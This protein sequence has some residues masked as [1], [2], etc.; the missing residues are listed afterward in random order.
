MLNLSYLERREKIEA[1]FDRT[2]ADAWKRLTSTEPVSG[3]RKTVREGRDR[4]RAT[5]LS[6][7]PE[8]MAGMRMLDAGC[9]TGALAVEAA[10]RGATVVAIDLSPTLVDLAR[11]RSSGLDVPGSIQY[12]AGDMLHPSHGRFDYI[13]CMDSLIHYQATDTV[14]ALAG[15]ISR[16][17]QAV[18]TTFAPQTPSLAIMRAVGRMFPKGDRA[19]WIE[20]VSFDTLKSLIA[21]EPRC[22]GWNP[23]RTQRISSSFY[24]S[25]ALELRR[26]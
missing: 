15:L 18:I 1:Y 20:P 11:Q 2:A 25:Q 8:D 24:K 3:I 9:G 5:I 4:M 17:D 21:A 16:A 6:W 12:L 7:L 13:V 23:A 22:A 19:P 14:Q 10:G 26:S